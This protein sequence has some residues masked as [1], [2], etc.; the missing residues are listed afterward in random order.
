MYS[1]ENAKLLPRMDANCIK[2]TVTTS[3]ILHSIYIDTI[4]Y[5]SHE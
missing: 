3:T 4:S 1:E 5:D 2:I